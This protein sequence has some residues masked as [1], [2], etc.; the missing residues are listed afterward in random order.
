MNKSNQLHP[1][2]MILHITTRAAWEE[3][4]PHGEY[5]APSLSIEGFIHCSTLSQILPVAENF[6][7][8][9]KGLVLLVI[10]PALLASALRWEAPFERI[11]PSGISEGEKFPH[12]YGHI[13]LN[14]V[15]KVVDFEE[16][17]SG[18][19]TLPEL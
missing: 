4:Q 17:E 11:L 12:V 7:K 2:N 15:V 8:G 18:E 6:Y 3:A 19:F 9:K 14:A 5:S 16:S 10:D 1:E 13:N